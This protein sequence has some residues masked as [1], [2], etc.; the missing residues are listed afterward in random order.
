MFG[1]EEFIESGG[2]LSDLDEGISIT[3]DMTESI[4]LTGMGDDDIKVTVNEIKKTKVVNRDVISVSSSGEETKL[5]VSGG[6]LEEL[7]NKHGISQT[8]LAGIRVTSID[9]YSMEIPSEILKNKEV[10]LAY[11]ID[12][13][14]LFKESG[15]IRIVVPEERAM[16]WVRNVSTIGIA[17]GGEIAA[18]GKRIGRIL[19]FDTAISDLDKQDY[20][21][22]GYLDKAIKIKDLL[23]KFIPEGEKQV[24]IK[25]ADGLRRNETRETFKDAFIKITGMES[26]MFLSPDLPGGMSVKGILWFS[27]GKIAFLT[28]DKALET[29]SKLTR[30]GIEGILLKEALEDIGLTQGNTYVFMANDAY[31][32]EISK[33]DIHRGMLY[34]ANDGNPGVSFEGMSKNTTVR[35]L[36]SIE[37]R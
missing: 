28:M 34:K 20:K 5:R 26:P 18:T 2:E 11:E 25:A 12:G 22:C 7:L 31:S 14:P 10:I 29:Y 8:E 3:G 6:L 19:I 24:C 4:T 1:C 15:P 36:L 35:N 9:G 32:V 17:D 27:S 30:K 37:I 33:D 13:K 16:Y 21:F 23:N